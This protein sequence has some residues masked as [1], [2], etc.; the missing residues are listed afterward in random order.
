MAEV[1]SRKTFSRVAACLGIA[2]SGG[3]VVSF[4]KDYSKHFAAPTGRAM[5]YGLVCTGLIL[6]FIGLILYGALRVLKPKI[7]TGVLAKVNG[8]FVNRKH[9]E[10]VIYVD[11]QDYRFPLDSNIDVKL[12]DARGETIQVRMEVGAFRRPICLETR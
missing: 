1:Y 8:N 6:A 11:N 2:I 4:W 9:N 3:M 7:V 5:I 10:L 12:N